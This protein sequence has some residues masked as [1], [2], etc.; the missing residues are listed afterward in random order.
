[1]LHD[2]RQ[3]PDG[4]EL[5]ADLCIVG[6]GAVGIT[7]AREL[8]GGPLK[9]VLLESG[10][11]DFDPDT[12]ALYAGEVVG[13]P[14]ADPEYARLRY[15]GGSSNHW[16][17][18][19]RPLD[20][21][22]FAARPWIPWSGWPIGPTD[23][24]PFYPR[25]REVLE[26]HSDDYAASG[27]AGQLSPILTG[28]LGRGRLAPVV[29]Q[30]SPPTRLGQRYRALL[31]SAPNIDVQLHANLVDIVTDPSACE[32]VALEAACLGGPRFTVRARV[33]V[34]A[35]GGIENARLLLAAN[36]V[37]PAGLGNTH[38]LVGR[39]FMDHPAAEAA[40]V[41]F[42]GDAEQV[43]STG[44]QLVDGG[45]VLS[46][47]TE[48]AEATGR[49]YCQIYPARGNGGVEET[50]YVALRRLARSLRRGQM[51]ADFNTQLGLV[52][53]DLDGA[54]SGLWRRFLGD[55]HALG[56]RL[57]PE[58]VPNPDSR[59]TLT[60]ERDALGLP[61]IRHDWRLSAIDR[62]GY[63]RGLAIL[64][65][66]LGR[67][68]LGRLRAA[69]WLEAE[70]FVFP[71]DGSWHHCGTTRMNDDPKQGVVDR[72]CL[73]HGMANLYVGGSS[74]FPTIGFANPT[75]TITAL[76]LRLADHLAARLA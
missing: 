38:D 74:V 46:E 3:L 75:F 6:G 8:A 37:M 51:P 71:G 49:F 40:E 48:R 24:E 12:Q 52:A 5:Q 64:G 65:E 76:S 69:E 19:C 59:I 1:M 29:F 54:A 67:L 14:G 73:V 61:R 10:G 47:A 42:T 9:V 20:P 45:F 21:I 15:L 30:L 31:E 68:G 41:L 39:F 23:L 2:A 32:V 17:G 72:D 28:P 70:P 33:T 56:V 22:D 60:A 50:G 36:R 58:V 55:I 16:M 26:L 44:S 57:H 27:W 66:E 43:R 13:N 62:H 34:L 7:L 4:T 35:T 18:Y 53:S 63:A 25:V 11:L